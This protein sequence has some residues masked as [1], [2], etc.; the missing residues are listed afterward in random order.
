[1]HNVQDARSQCKI[2]IVAFRHYPN[3]IEYGGTKCLIQRANYNF[4]RPILLHL[5]EFC[6][7]IW[8]LRWIVLG[9]L[10]V[11]SFRF[12]RQTNR[13]D[14]WYPLMTS[15][16]Y[17]DTFESICIALLIKSLIK[18]LLSHGMKDIE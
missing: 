11:A 3:Q 7:G 15:C 16:M 14:W 9:I 6:G 10:S 2:H 8:R 4:K 1:M 5:V 12:D 13:K 17:L 18:A